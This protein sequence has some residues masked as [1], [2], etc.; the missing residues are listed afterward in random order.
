MALQHMRILQATTTEA[1]CARVLMSSEMVCEAR[2]SSLLPA[3]SALFLKRVLS[4]LSSLSRPR[5]SPP[6]PLRPCVRP[7]PRR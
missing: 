7:H 3:P 4:N 6:P 1:A 5:R 2:T